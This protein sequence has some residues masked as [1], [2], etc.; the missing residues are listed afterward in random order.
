MPPETLKPIIE[1]A[2]LAAGR[3]LELDQL[4]ELFI[5]P[6]ADEEI[7]DSERQAMRKPIRQVLKQLVADCENSERGI[8]LVEIASGYRLQVKPV[9]ALYVRNLWASRPSR[10]SRALL[11]TLALIAYRQPITRSD[12]EKVRGVTVSTQI[13]KNL[14]EYGWIRIVGHRNTPGRPMLYGTTKTFLDHFG[15]KSLEELPSLI[16]LQDLAKNDAGL[17]KESN[18]VE[19]LSE[20]FVGPHTADAAHEIAGEEAALTGIEE[21]LVAAEQQAQHTPL[22]ADIR[23]EEEDEAEDD[24]VSEEDIAET[25]KKLQEAERRL[26]E[27]EDPENPH[28]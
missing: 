26:L 21:E 2:L 24:E 13:I 28:V 14:L 23:M 9:H 10:Y 6:G 5:T 3:P 15:L 17:L 1:A 27:S 19:L 11:E 22:P 16:E 25:M 20:L 18:E 7:Q 12:I 4:C 8:E